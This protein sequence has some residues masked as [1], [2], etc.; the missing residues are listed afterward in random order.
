[1]NCSWV[2]TKRMRLC[3]L[4]S[5]LLLY[6]M[7]YSVGLHLYKR[8]HLI[9][10]HTHDT[11]TKSFYWCISCC[12]L[13]TNNTAISSCVCIMYA[14]SFWQTGKYILRVSYKHLKVVLSVHINLYIHSV[15]TYPFT[16]VLDNTDIK[17]LPFWKG[18]KREHTELS[19]FLQ[20]SSSSSTTS[21]SQS[22]LFLVLLLITEL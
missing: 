10:F 11:I 3:L 8:T 13:I 14:C 2:C 7:T 1:M 18:E 17:M 15:Y 20:P 12:F 5:I 9:P 4:F 21:T 19:E 6:S 16:Y 22:L